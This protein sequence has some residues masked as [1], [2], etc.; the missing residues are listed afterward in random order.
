MN[1]KQRIA[2]NALGSRNWIGGIQ[3]TQNLVL[4]LAQLPEEVRKQYEI[5]LIGSQSKINFLEDLEKS[6]DQILSENDFQAINFK[7]KLQWKLIR[8]FFD[9]AQQKFEEIL[10]Q[11]EGIDFIYPYLPPKKRI[12]NYRSA[13][14]IFDFQHKYLP[15]F[16]KE[17]EIKGRDQNFANIASKASTVVLSSK[18]AEKDFWKF[19]PNSQAQT[20]VLQFKTF[21]NREW[22]E[23]NPVEIQKKYYL[24]NKFF[25]ISNQFW[26]HKNHLVVFEAL[27]RLKS[28][29][30]EPI[31]VCTGYFYDYRKPEY[32]DQVLETIHCSGLAHQVYLLGLIDRLD[33]IQLMRRSI[34]LIQ[35]SLFEG[36]ST[37]I[38]DARC[39]GKP[40][41]MSDLEV[42]IEQNPPRNQVFERHS[43]E[44]LAPII[45]DW[46]EKL[47]PGP[48]YEKEKQARENNLVEVQKFGYRFLDI[49]QN[50]KS[51]EKMK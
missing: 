30:I 14:W 6:V 4:A 50:A 35:P 18:T 37:V 48:D 32:I 27:Q 26:Q 17:A 28:Q 44:S 46:W 49:A 31:V 29:S 23:P 5:I 24:P 34:A 40:V 11:R 43:S 10:I 47:L 42:N 13:T 3:Y 7:E 16:F 41:I 21:P 2:I 33:Q 15:D 20:E 39:L 9:K 45:A 12:K 1:K 19:F 25:L 51:D 36:W 22:Y 38:E 8:L